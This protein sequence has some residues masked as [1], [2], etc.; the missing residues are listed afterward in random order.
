WMWGLVGAALAASVVAASAQEVL[1]ANTIGYIK[2]ELPEAGKMICLSVP[3]FSMTEGS[4]VF[5]RT[6][7]AQEAPNG[8]SV[9]FWNTTNQ[10]WV[11]GTKSTKG[12][13]A[14]GQSNYVIQAGEGFFL[15]SPTNAATAT[16][17]TV[18]GE[19][20]ALASQTRAVMGAANLGTVANPYP[21]DFQFGSSD[22]AKNA[23]N[24]STVYFWNETNQVWVG[25]T[26]S[27]KGVWAAGQSNY[28]VKATEG[29]FLKTSNATSW[30][31]TNAKPYTWP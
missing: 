18:A 11:G 9:Y 24:G 6:S 31:W 27:T 22:L 14:A 4:N 8:S 2:K 1:S 29:F 23:A 28:V 15:R 19:V 17:I 16:E 3:L 5:G 30:V 20:P 12:V 21:A 25:G 13:W 26:K 7:F 10:V